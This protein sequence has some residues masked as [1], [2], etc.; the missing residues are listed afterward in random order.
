MGAFKTDLKDETAYLNGIGRFDI[1]VNG[2]EAVQWFQSEFF[3]SK[4]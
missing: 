3:P 1:Q 2:D 4:L